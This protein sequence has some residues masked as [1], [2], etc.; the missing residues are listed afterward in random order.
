MTTILYASPVYYGVPG[1][2][3]TLGGIALALVAVYAFTIL[4]VHRKKIIQGCKNIVV[5]I[6]SRKD[7]IVRA[8]HVIDN[9]ISIPFP[10]GNWIWYIAFVCFFLASVV[11]VYIIAVCIG[12]VSYLHS[13]GDNIFPVV[14]YYP[15]ATEPTIQMLYGWNSL[16]LLLGFWY[17]L[18]AFV[19]DTIRAIAY[20]IPATYRYIM[21]GV[22]S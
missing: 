14:Q 22:L 10:Y 13:I 12:Q 15:L 3:L 19:L 17:F 9:I 5:A 18:I 2:I 11:S 21:E 6:T 7:K 16:A 8:F 20:R 4:C 1:D